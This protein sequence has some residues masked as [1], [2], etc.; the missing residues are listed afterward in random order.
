MAGNFTGAHQAYWEAARH[1]HGD[2]AETR[3][4]IDQSADST[5]PTESIRPDSR[6]FRVANVMILA[7][8][9]MNR[10][11]SMSVLEVGASARHS[12]S[13]S[14]PARQSREQHGHDLGANKSMH[15]AHCDRKIARLCQAESNVSEAATR[16]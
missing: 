1:Q 14:G 6:R 4:L 2:V 9:P 12:S 13:G 8:G 7:L 15:A 10:L 16:S 3:A 11:Y 5:L